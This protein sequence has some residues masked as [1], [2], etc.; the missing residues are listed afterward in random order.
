VSEYASHHRNHGLGWRPRLPGLLTETMDLQDLGD[1]VAYTA[2]A[3]GTPVC[4]HQRRRIDVI[5]QVMEVGAY[6]RG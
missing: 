3:D 4:D 1:L 6:W 5:E 2:I